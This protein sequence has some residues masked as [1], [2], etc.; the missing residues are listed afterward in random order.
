VLKQ[1]QYAPLPMEEQVA[2][3]FA[4]TRG[5]LDEVPV[6]KVRAFEQRFLEYLREKH[7]GV[8]AGIRSLGTLPEPGILEAILT[9]FKKEF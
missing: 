1:S 3:L 9:E 5:F 4:A 7:P 6:N 8:L 2:I